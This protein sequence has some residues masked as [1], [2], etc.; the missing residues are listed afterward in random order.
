MKDRETIR[1]YIEFLKKKADVSCASVVL[2]IVPGTSWGECREIAQD[3]ADTFCG[4]YDED[5]ECIL[6]EL[7]DVDLS[8][9]C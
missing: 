4:A 7:D 8:E 2:K 9:L 5:D 1:Q 6:V 3:M